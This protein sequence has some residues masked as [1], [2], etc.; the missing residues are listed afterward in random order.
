MFES[1]PAEASEYFRRYFA[2]WMVPALLIYSGTAWLLWRRV[3]PVYLSRRSAWVAVVLILVTLF[4][5]RRSR[6]SAAACF[7]PPSPPKR[8]RSAW[9]LP[10]LADDGRLPAIPEQLSGM[11]E[12]LDQNNSCR[13]SAIS[14]MPTA[15]RRPSSLVIG[16]STNRQQHEPLRLSAPDD[17]AAGRIARRTHRLQQR[18]RSASVH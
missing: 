3:R 4:A 15:A 13:R 7:R 16:E 14:S 10:C 12:L 8:S 6:T 11:Q 9:S 5:F 2:W 18:D 17:A 1:D